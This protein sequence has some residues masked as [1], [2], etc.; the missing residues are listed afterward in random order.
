[1]PSGTVRAGLPNSI[2][3]PPSMAK[4]S[5]AAQACTGGS[6]SPKSPPRANHLFQSSLGGP[7][8]FANFSSGVR[9]PSE[10]CDYHPFP[11]PI[12]GHGWLPGP[13]LTEGSNRAPLGAGGDMYG[14]QLGFADC[15]L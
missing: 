4:T 11:T 14:N 5:R 9:W 7:T 1:M 3:Q 13:G 15:H 10:I 6:T 2:S 8:A 12:G